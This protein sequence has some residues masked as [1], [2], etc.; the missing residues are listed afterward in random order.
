MKSCLSLLMAIALAGCALSPVSD[1]QESPSES[2]PSVP[3][4]TAIEPNVSFE[5]KA[6]S[7]TCPEMVDLWELLW[8]FEGG[9]DH[10]VVVNTPAIAAAPPQILRSTDRAV[11]YQAPLN[12]QYATCVGT[13]QSD[14]LR[15]YT[16]RFA[17]G[18]V[19][20]DIDLSADDGF[21][22]IRYADISANRP[23]VHWRA[24][25]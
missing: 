7:G 10:T 8:G 16:F 11:T 9:A 14:Y 19:A 21:R 5:V 1:A 25:E 23:Y 22:E 4:Q 15:M 6:E 18:T 2:L 24:A 3:W 17:R 12:D 20:F 13:A